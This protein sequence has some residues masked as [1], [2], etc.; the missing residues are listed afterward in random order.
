VAGSGWLFINK[1]P[2]STNDM[3][4]MSDVALTN[5]AMCAALC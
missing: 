4:M 5:D 3:L 2:F 1:P